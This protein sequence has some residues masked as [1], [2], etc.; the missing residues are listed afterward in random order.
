MALSHWFRRHMR[1]LLVAVAVLLMVGWGLLPALRRMQREDGPSLGTIRGEEIRRPD[2]AR[3][4]DT[5]QL[6][7]RL[8]L[9]D[10]R[11]YMSMAYGGVNP[12]TQSLYVLL[13]GPFRNFVFPEGQRLTG[14]AVWR[15]L[16][17]LREAE[18]AGVE[19]TVAETEQLLAAV[20]QLR[21]GGEFSRDM[22]ARLLRATNYRDAMVTQSFN[23]LT[24]VLKLIAARRAAVLTTHPE[25]W[26]AYAFRNEQARI[27]FIALDGELFSP[28]VEASREQLQAF[29]EER[30]DRL[31][32][33]DE[34]TYGYMAPER[35][36]LEY[37]IAPVDEIAGEVE[38]SQEEMAA[39]Y[40]ENKDEYALPEESPSQE[41]RY[42]PLE[43]VRGQILEELNTA[44]THEEA[45][46]RVEA[47]MS[48]L[49]TAGENY[50]GGPQPLGQMARRHGLRY[51]VA[52]VG[53]GRELLSRQE[54]T[55]R[56]PAGSQVAEFAFGGP[57]N[58]YFP[59]PITPAEG[60]FMIVQVLEHRE[61]EQQEFSEVE[62]Q[63]RRDYREAHGLDRAVTF[64]RK[65]EALANEVGLEDAAEQMRTRL[66][67]LL[68]GTEAAPDA[69]EEP[70]LSVEETQ[71]FSRTTRHVPGL[72]AEAPQVVE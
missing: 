5:L 44:K 53:E 47:A 68:G 16:V 51:Q 61:P 18:T 22:Y 42:R 13:F 1:E 59:T 45:N 67:N 65:V 39:Y 12:A 10:P 37:A 60:P 55:E 32:D 19:A 20:P 41:T 50:G 9:M 14:E 33:A 71:L 7:L 2:V 38:I 23:E 35:V 66:T 21:Q 57:E 54:V 40:E 26:M 69:E 29:Y 52:S 17:L 43:E 11:T 48:D 56:V 72:E 58:L 34:G 46:R 49:A 3:A 8:G 63:V 30:K 27:R 4:H 28:L 36:R 24:K 15:Y 64:A 31:P 70:L 62:Q 25:R 6:A